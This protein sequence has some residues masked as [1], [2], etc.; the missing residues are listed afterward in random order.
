M[1]R[2]QKLQALIPTVRSEGDGYYTVASLSCPGWRYLVSPRT[3]TS[4]ARCEC[5]GYRRH[6]ERRC[7]HLE[8]VRAVYRATHPRPPTIREDQQRMGQHLQRAQQ[9]PQHM[10]LH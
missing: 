9:R 4:P 5:E 7:S 3:A 10:T 1:N 2:Q 8:A 6:P